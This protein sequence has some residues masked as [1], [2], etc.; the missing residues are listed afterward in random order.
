MD[1]LNRWLP[2]WVVAPVVLLVVL[3]VVIASLPGVECGGEGAEGGTEAAVV[4]VLTILSS[5]ATV[6]AGL[7]RLGAMALNRRFGRRD[8]AIAAAA[9]LLLA[10]APLIDGSDRSAG[11]SLAIGGLV[12]TGLSGLG[13]MAA[14]VARLSIDAVGILLPMYL[15]GAAY[16]YLLLG[17]I[18]LLAVSGAGC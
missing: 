11:E 10:L 15:F 12:L 4:V 13:L 16:V 17:G 18:G 3:F 1:R 5:L 14:A 8:L 6:A 2:L 7:L 9:A